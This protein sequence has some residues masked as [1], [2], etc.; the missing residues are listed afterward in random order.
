[1][2]AALEAGQ[3]EILSTYET[4]GDYLTTQNQNFEQTK[5]SAIPQHVFCCALREEDVALRKEFDTAILKISSDGTLAHLVKAYIGGSTDLPAI[6]MPAF[7]GADTIKIGVTGDLPLLDYIR[8]DNMPAGFNT[9]VLSEI[10]QRIG[11][12]FVLVQVAGGARAVALT[13]GKVDVIFWAVVPNEQGNIPQD[14]DKPVGVI[15][16]KPYFADEIVHVKLKK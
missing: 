11:K 6:E 1:M 4:V 7:Y 5:F 9:A 14:F 8:P 2:V 10:S 13:S 3:I 12:N 16:T 15:L